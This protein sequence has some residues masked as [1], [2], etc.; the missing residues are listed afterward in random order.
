MRRLADFAVAFLLFRF[1]MQVMYDD[2]KA[3]K[4]GKRVGRVLG[5]RDP[6]S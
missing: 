4:F 3:E 1:A 6:R 2:E 5:I